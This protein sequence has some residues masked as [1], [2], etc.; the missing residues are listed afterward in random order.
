MKYKKC[1]GLPYMGSKRRLAKN[2][3]DHIL[4]KNPKTEYFFDLFGGGG[5]VSF[6][7][8]QRKCIKQVVYNEL[9]TGVCELL[10][11]LQKDGVTEEMY[12]W[13]DRETFHKLKDGNDW[14]A[15]LVKT[16]WSFGNNQVSYM[17]GKHIEEPKRLLHEVIVNKCEKSLKSFNKHFNINLEISEMDGETVNERRLQIQRIMKKQVKDKSVLKGFCISEENSIRSVSQQLQQLER[18]QQLEIQ[19]KSYKDV[20][21][22]TP[23]ENTI[24]YLDP[25]YENTGEYQKKLDHKESKDWIFKS[26]YKI[27]MSSY[28]CDYMHEVKSWKHRTKFSA[29][30]NNEVEEKL[31]CNRQE[32][33]KKRFF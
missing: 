7:A 16:C 13:V 33:E 21:I 28:K 6:E 9:N 31:F 32:I 14:K 19:N 20:E 8:M 11:K 15:G 24:I 25:P 18:L 3:V 29:T 2:I 23:I 4:E 22:K 5:A 26:K 30:A 12:E 17:F 27:Y 10:K 1:L